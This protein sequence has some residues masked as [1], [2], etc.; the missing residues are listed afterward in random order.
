M[1]LSD[2]HYD[3]RGGESIPISNNFMLLRGMEKYPRLHANT[4]ILI[5]WIAASPTAP[6]NDK[7]PSSRATEGSVAI[8]NF[9][10][11]AFNPLV[12]S[13]FQTIGFSR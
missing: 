9:F 13:V 10:V 7:T 5:I 12:P 1:I 2:S 4:S 11:Y 6:R 8:Q 3:V